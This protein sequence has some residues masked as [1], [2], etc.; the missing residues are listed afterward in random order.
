MFDS[1]QFSENRLTP[2][3][4]VSSSSKAA[5]FDLHLQEQNF[6][7]QKLIDD[8]QQY[9]ENDDLELYYQPQIDLRTG[10]TRSVEALVRWQ[11]R[12]AGNIPPHIFVPLAEQ[13]GHIHNL[14]LWVLDNALQEMCNWKYSGM[15]MNV[16]VNL[17]VNNLE[18]NELPVKV[19]DLLEKWSVPARQL[20]LEV[21]ESVMIK[22]PKHASKILSGLRELGVSLSLDDYGSGY[23]SLSYLSNLP[24]NEL[25]IDRSLV[26]DMDKNH[27]NKKIVQSTIELAKSLGLG[28]VAEGVENINA[29]S[30]L[31]VLN[32]DAAQGFYFCKPICSKEFTSWLFD[33]DWGMGVN[34]CYAN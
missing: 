2:D 31:T 18:D 20:I 12:F 33:S 7:Q 16:A 5:T 24:I 13:S 26:M 15:E 4:E 29:Y 21:T 10:K 19:S 23:S 27:K 1:L 25:K 6:W 11:H 32:C 30:K 14:T 22:N 34:V 9:I 28:V 8:L 3:S 17:S